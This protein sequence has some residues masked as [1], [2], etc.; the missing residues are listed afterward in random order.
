MMQL[1]MGR[2]AATG[3]ISAVG[4]LL[5]T[6]NMQVALLMGLWGAGASWVAEKVASMP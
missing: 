2:K 4:A 5:L 1:P 3:A 6:R